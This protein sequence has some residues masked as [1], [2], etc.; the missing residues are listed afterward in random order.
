MTNAPT[1]TERFFIPAAVPFANLTAPPGATGWRIMGRSGTAADSPFAGRPELHRASDFGS[2]FPS[3][4][5]TR[6][7]LETVRIAMVPFPAS[8]AD[9]PSFETPRDRHRK[10]A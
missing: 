9:G 8:A 1:F 10:W 4:S 7:I 3:M 5:T 2:A 6:P